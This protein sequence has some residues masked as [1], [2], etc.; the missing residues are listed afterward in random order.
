MELLKTIFKH[1]GSD[2]GRRPIQAEPAAGYDLWAAT[3]DNQPRNLMFHLDEM[4]FSDL[5]ARTDLR[6]K[7]VVDIG[8]GTGRHWGKILRQKPAELAGYDVSGEMLKRLREK[9]P[10][11]HVWLLHGQGLKETVDASCD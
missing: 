7:T 9:Y 11:A 3:Y 4:L 8:C 5:L 10:A 1:F 2:S 6:N